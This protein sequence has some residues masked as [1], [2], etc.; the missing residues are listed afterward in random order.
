MAVRI[1]V[2]LIYEAARVSLQVEDNGRGFT[3]GVGSGP[4]HYGIRGMR[5]RAGEIDAAFVLES[6]PGK[7]TRVLVEAPVEATVGARG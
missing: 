3:P 5:E 1:D 7:G 2:Q 4:G 6:A